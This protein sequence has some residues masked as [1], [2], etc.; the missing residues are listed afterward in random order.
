MILFLMFCFSSINMFIKLGTFYFHHLN[1]VTKI[2][3]M[4]HSNT[5]YLHFVHIPQFVFI[6]ISLMLLYISLKTCITLQLI[7]CYVYR[8]C[9][10]F[11]SVF[12]I[13]VLFFCNTVSLV[14]I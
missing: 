10:S 14:S 9:F 5:H 1:M 3:I 13:S 7:M 6:F 11:R 12:L 8:H 4:Y 2:S